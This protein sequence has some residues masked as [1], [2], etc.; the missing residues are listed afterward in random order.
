[1][2]TALGAE[3]PLRERAPRCSVQGM[4]HPADGGAIREAGHSFG[5]LTVLGCCWP[6]DWE[7][8]NRVPNDGK[9]RVV[10]NF[11]AWLLPGFAVLECALQPGMITK[12]FV[13]AILP[14]LIGLSCRSP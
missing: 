14:G 8:S 2:G 5:H 4:A 7:R 9:V 12:C 6:I 1:M 3:T 11:L 13:R 10:L